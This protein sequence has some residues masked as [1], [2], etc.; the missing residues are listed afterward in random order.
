VS[1]PSY[2]SSSLLKRISDQGRTVEATIVDRCAGCPGGADLDFSI[3][4][5]SALADPSVGRLYGVEWDYE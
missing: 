4:A 5:F 2:E 1:P 3:V